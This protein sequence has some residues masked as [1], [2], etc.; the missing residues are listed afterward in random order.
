MIKCDGIFQDLCI[1]GYSV[2]SQ[3]LCIEIWLFWGNIMLF[4]SDLD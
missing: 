4:F 2:A 1:T 3:E